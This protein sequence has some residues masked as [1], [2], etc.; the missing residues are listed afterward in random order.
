MTLLV[1]CL[2]IIRLRTISAH[3]NELG[4]RTG[5]KT[6][7]QCV[8]VQVNVSGRAK[9]TITVHILFTRLTHLLWNVIYAHV[10]VALIQ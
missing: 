2:R 5:T 3:L 4:G 7:L 10:A 9:T 6:I 1:H 8:Q